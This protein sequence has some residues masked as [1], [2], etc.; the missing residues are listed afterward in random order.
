MKKYYNSTENAYYYE[1]R[2]MTKRLSA[3]SL[4]S[5]IPNAE[6][7]AE[8]GY[9]EVVEQVVEPTPYVPTYEELVVQK[10]REQY[11]LDDEL[12]IQRQKETKP[13]EWQTYYD[14]CEACKADAKEELGINE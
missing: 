5:G 8:W 6:Q 13:E 2:P 4:W 11:T 1:G 3:S 12:A 7:L 10:I 14:Y 9:E